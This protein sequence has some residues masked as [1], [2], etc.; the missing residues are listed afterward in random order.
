MLK[1]EE[2]PGPRPTTGRGVMSRGEGC[3]RCSAENMAQAQSRHETEEWSVDWFASS[4][5]L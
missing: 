4:T 1:T 3:E 2:L 5:D